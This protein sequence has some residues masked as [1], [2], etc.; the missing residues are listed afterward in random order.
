MLLCS[1]TV[2]Q[3]TADSNI[4]KTKVKG[5]RSVTLEIWEYN[6]YGTPTKVQMLN[7]RRTHAITAGS[8]V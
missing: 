6:F 3:G 5:V 1:L 8:V 7:S 2:V 4:E